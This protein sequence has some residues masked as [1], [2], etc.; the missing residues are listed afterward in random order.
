MTHEAPEGWSQVKQGDVATFY[1]G[2]AYK[3]T[4]W[5]EAGTPVIRLQNLTGR[6]NKYYYSKLELP[7]H[8]YCDKGDLLYMWSATFGPHIW[9]ND[10][11]IYHYH[12]WKVICDES[13]LDR[14][15]HYYLL[16]QKTKEWMSGANGMA[17]L[18]ITKGNMEKVELHIPPLPEQKKIA[19]VLS[20]V[21][22]AIAVTKAVIDQTKQVKKGLL[23]TLLTKG[24]GHT[25]FKQ[26]ELG[27]IPES[28]EYGNVSDFFM[29]QRGFDL[30]K[31]QAHDG[32]V[33]VISSSGF[34]YFHN[35]AQV[36][37]PAVITGRKGKLGDVYYIE[38]PCWPH[39]TTLWVKDFKGNHPRFVF[40]FLLS[41]E[42]EKYDAATAVP[43]L[44]RNT[45]HP[46]K[47][48][49]PPLEEQIE[50]SDKLDSLN[51]NFETSEAHLSQLQTLKSGLISDLLTGRKRVEV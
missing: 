23:Q 45:V 34:S 49:F 8:Q 29:L 11:A 41:M 22:E 32:D 26:T 4:E 44:N 16:G 28:W 42:L 51:S 6:G 13:R 31:K 1:N 36:H 9:Q 19:E 47:T 17:M 37:G 46:I 2:R 10:K 50:I 21:D 14:K 35:T 12:I 33:P 25:K 43:T 27:E 30:T 40:W 20:S 3:K 39:D 48:I 24:I 7:E 15:F 38:G 5:E 18:H